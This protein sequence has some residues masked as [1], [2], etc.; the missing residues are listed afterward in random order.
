MVNVPRLDQLRQTKKVISLKQKKY[1]ISFVGSLYENNYYEQIT[2]LPAHLKGYLDGI[3]RAQM[4]LSGVDILPE[5]LREDILTELNEYVKLDMDQTYLVTYGRLFSDLFLKKYISSMERKERLEL[6]GKISRVALFS[7]S[8]LGFC[9]SSRRTVTD[10]RSWENRRR[11][12]QRGIQRRQLRLVGI[13][14]C[15]MAG[16]KKG[17]R[18]RL[19]TLHRTL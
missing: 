18:Q 13:R 10:H 17:I 15:E 6:L 11:R 19:S 7:G 14:K 3:C 8:R 4:Q 12:R 1:D 2:Y 5:L 9:G 16:C